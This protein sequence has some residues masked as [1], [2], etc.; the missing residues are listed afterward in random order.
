[1]IYSV[2]T[3]M[4]SLEINLL[5]EKLKVSR[6]YLEFGAGYSTMVACSFTN[7]NVFSFETDVNYCRYIESK[8][9][10]KGDFKNVTVIHVD[11]GPTRDWGWPELNADVAK[12]SNYL[13]TPV[14]FM[15]TKHFKPDLIL[16]DGRFRVATFFSCLLEFPGVEIM[17]DDYVDRDHYHI[18][19]EVI[20][21]YKRV[22]RIALFKAPKRL[23]RK[24]ILRSLSL[25]NEYVVEPS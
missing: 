3:T 25:I 18:V 1:M 24:R 2:E 7:L 9:A 17:F 11:I 12:F 20:K 22:G 21:P 23:S 8:L 19:E 16:V 13:W 15:K 10:E 14:N 4:A 6:N 5:I